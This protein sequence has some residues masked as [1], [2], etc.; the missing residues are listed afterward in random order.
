MD[1]SAGRL[2][3]GFITL[4]VF[5]A[6]LAAAVPA[7]GADLKTLSLQ[8]AASR[9]LANSPELRDARTGIRQK[10]SELEQARYARKS[11][12][13]KAAGPFAK[14]RNLSQ[15]L[16]TGMKVPEAQMQLTVALEQARQTS[17][18][19][20]NDAEQSYLTAF[21]AMLAE[22]AARNKRDEA[23][24]EADA[25]GQKLKY[26]LAKQADKEKAAQA[27]ERASSAY[28]QAQLAAKGAR[29]A[30]G[31]KIGTSLEQPV[32]M[33]F[34]PVYADLSERAL[35]GY[36]SGALAANTALIRDVESRRLADE[37]LNATRQLYASKFGAGRMKAF[38][39]MYD[40][41]N[42]DMDL[43]TASYE[44][45]LE[46]VRQDWEGYYWI[47]FPI[48][49][50]LFQG[51]FDGL[52][53]LD[54]LR[55][56]LPLATM[57]QGKAALKEKESREA[58]IAAVRQTYL[59]AKTAEEAYAQALRA[60][61][62]AFGA[63][64]KAESKRK[65]GLSP[66][67]ELEQAEEA[68]E[69]ADSQVL[70]AQIAYMGA[71]GKLNVDTGG[72]LERTYK[73]GLLPYKGIDDGL[74]PVQPAPVQPASGKWTL[75]PAI[76]ELLSEFTAVPDKRL[77]ATD[78]VLIGEGGRI[79]GGKTKAGKPVRALTVVLAKPEQ[80][81]IALY[82]G[83]ELIGEAPLGGGTS[84]S[85]TIAPAQP[86]SPAAS[87]GDSA[88]G[89][90]AGTSGAEVI[91]GTT[92]VKLEALSEAVYDA[93]AATV[94]TS[95]QGIVYSPDG[96]TWFSL[97]RITDAS[98]LNDPQGAAALSSEQ[99]QALKITI[100]V[101]GK[102]AVR[103][104]LS[105]T[106]L[107]GEIARLT[108]ELEKLEAD[109]KAAVDAGKGDLLA[110]IAIRA[111]EAKAQKAMLEALKAGDSKAAMKQ[112]A[113]V[114]SPE[115]LLAGLAEA[116]NGGSSGSGAGETPGTGQGSGAGTGA[117]EPGSAE[118]LGEDELE[119]L[120]GSRQ[121]EL[122][123]AVLSG[124]AA[125]AIK[126]LDALLDAKGKAAEASGGFADGLAVLAEAARTLN[127]DRAKAEQAG[128]KAKAEALAATLSAVQT[129]QAQLE[130]ERLFAGLE[131]VREVAAQLA[132][133]PPPE[134]GT[135]AA[136]L[137]E[138]LAARLDEQ[139]AASLVRLIAKQK[140]MY[141]EQQ[142]AE[143]ER[144]AEQITA[145]TKGEAAPLPPEHLLSPSAP[146]KT[147]IPP[148]IRAGNTFIPLRAVS[149]SFGAAVDWAE[150][151]R[152]A[153]VST[154]YGTIQCTIGSGIAYVNGEL[155]QLEAAPELT[156]GRTF[157]PLRFLA[158]SL[159]IEV[160]WNGETS[161]IELYR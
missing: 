24:R 116:Q 61:E 73:P 42:I 85:F 86:D 87:I 27:L 160:V 2:K 81:R 91:I 51:E 161:T 78:Y 36:I 22:Q 146:L 13:E 150:D 101:Q 70:S 98:A 131:A 37:K 50:K 113:L 90:A 94:K 124:D 133:Q 58:V 155:V 121:E 111:E 7:A 29:L 148:Y 156:A 12:E 65:L 118:T 83:D 4:L 77:K 26:G 54:D 137:R 64:G 122:L 16:Q 136:V 57:E 5:A 108:A 120:A 17:I 40:A 53:Y 129:S 112:M 139:E 20:K 84:G 76:G 138:Q 69:S 95:G 19:V 59:D 107:D 71:I 100:D 142:T 88:P 147:D 8:E 102:D 18:Q 115:A 55:N 38:D 31:G 117:A 110:A 132:A 32:A 134:P 151:T 3:L 49:K 99:L 158:E 114:G 140:D 43:F 109:K 106:E 45:L 103:S 11:E 154:S 67:E 143:L 89:A 6:P 74:S 104:L 14:P 128:D 126:A 157:V 82:R 123:R 141:G 119:A 92:K 125:T 159:G 33:T 60:R 10:Q 44:S 30:L 48:P 97:D 68:Y 149:E 135:A 56:G 152:T 130:K 46:Q 79:V 21:Q 63:L 127:A 47:I 105:P 145:E 96:K 75:R 80:M 144:L 39:R 15:Q 72:A 153:T 34:D 52:R 25:T 23:L 66:P 9:A 62:A 28:K 41:G 1:R 35:P 93:A